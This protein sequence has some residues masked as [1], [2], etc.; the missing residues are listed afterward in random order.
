MKNHQTSQKAIERADR[1]YQNALRALEDKRWDDVVY[2]YEMAVEQALKGILILYGIEYPKKHDIS[3]SYITLK[4][5]DV[6]SFF[7]EKIY[8]HVKN[9]IY[10]VEKRGI[11]AY[12]YV[13]NISIEDFKADALEFK[14]I[15]KEII[16]DCK[17][18]LHS[19]LEEKND[20]YGDI[21][22]PEQENDI[23]NEKNSNK[24]DHIDSE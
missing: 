8:L 2:S 10:L 7:K 20:D 12:G 13:E 18:L 14:D 21:S 4:E 11:A 5:A 15:V 23:N 17:R 6:P 16:H 22:R 1:W 24:S 19:Y 9:L 3:A